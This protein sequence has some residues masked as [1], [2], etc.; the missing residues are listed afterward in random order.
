[1]AIWRLTYV[2]GCAIEGVTEFRVDIIETPLSTEVWLREVGK[3]E[4]H[5]MFTY[6]C[7]GKTKTH[8]ELLAIAD[9][10]FE[11]VR[12]EMKM[13]AHMKAMQLRRAFDI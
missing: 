5:L 8:R 11:Y 7:K 12:M 6:E 4:A 10:I 13:E 3:D 1:M 2:V 9:E